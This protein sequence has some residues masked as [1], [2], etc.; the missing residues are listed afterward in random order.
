MDPLLQTLARLPSMAASPAP[1]AVDDAM[2]PRSGSSFFAEGCLPLDALQIDV[3]GIGPLPSPLTDTDGRALHALST[4]A[5]FGHFDTTLRDPSVRDTGKIGAELISLQWAD[6]AF[7]GLCRDVARALG[8]PSIEARLHNLLVYGPGQFFKPHQDTEKHPGMLATLVL[9]WPSSHIGGDLCVGHNGDQARFVSQH[10]QLG[11]LRWSAFYADCLHE[12]LP[13]QEGHRVVLSFDLVLPVASATAAEASASSAQPAHPLL[14][15]AFRAAFEP[16]AGTSGSTTAR[17]APWVFLLDHDYSERGLGWSRLKGADRPRV[18]ALRA[19]AEALGLTVDLALTEIHES[20]T[21][22]V[23][24]TGHRGGRGSAKADELIDE[25]ITLD[26]WID[27]QGRSTATQPLRVRREDLAGFAD[28]DEAFLVDEEYEGYMGNYGETLDCWYRRAAL[29]IRSPEAAAV[30]RFTI[31]FD[32]ALQEALQMAGDS[33]SSPKLAACLL[34]ARQALHQ[35]GGQ[36]G[37]ALLPS[38]ARLAIAWPD[39]DA[40]RALVASIDVGTWQPPDAP[41]LAGLEQ[42]RGAEW[43][44]ATIHAAAADRLLVRNASTGD[45]LASLWP[46]PLPDFVDAVARAGLGAGS[47][48]TLRAAALARLMAT[49][50]AHARSQ[51]AERQRTL[52][53]RQAL[54]LQLAAGCLQAPA[55]PTVL[56]ALLR[57]VMQ[58][59]ALYDPREQRSL[60]EGLG[61]AVDTEPQAAA[62]RSAVLTALADALAPAEPGDHDRSMLGLPWICRCADCKPMIFWAEAPNPE[63]LVL[64]MAER[65]RDHVAQMLAATG[66]PISTHTVKKGSPHQLVLQKPVDWPARRRAQRERWQRDSDALKA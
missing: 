1:G 33:T 2:S 59:P 31:D 38:Y 57:H 48:D 34:G 22:T 23:E 27:A 6:G 56:D 14:V 20:W 60:V 11:H 32:A 25:D 26:H 3:D 61:P 30:Q 12:V 29:V 64:A 36:R 19:A 39:A 35:Q 62:L 55:A 17:T 46:Q 45:P 54:V 40:A 7:A 44:R 9:L 42:A 10:L 43:L 37:R 15:E 28:T 16:P 51:P 50:E 21:A 5:A 13:V 41:V 8:L 58:H 65:R 4:P 49:D 52:A 63:P 53:R 24:Y 18:A 47:I 66:A